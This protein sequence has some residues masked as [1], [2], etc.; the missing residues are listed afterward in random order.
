MEAQVFAFLE[1]YV[2]LSADHKK[3]I[4]KH[5]TLR[6]YPKKTVLL[7]AG[8]TTN[9]SYFIFKGC[10]RSFVVRDGEEQTLEFYTEGQ[11]VTPIEH[12]TGERSIHYL[13]CVEDCVVSMSDETT[14]DAVYAESPEFESI[15]RVMSEV[16]SRFHQNSLVDYRLST[17]EERYLHLFETRPDL[18]QRVPQYQLASYLG[19]KPESLSRI[20]RRLSKK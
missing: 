7:K 19:V 15:C 16:M 4:R 13:E 9:Q 18:L 2:A 12:E 20:R 1:N 6:E 14:M 10:I 5:L 11:P 8:E 17:P 3:V